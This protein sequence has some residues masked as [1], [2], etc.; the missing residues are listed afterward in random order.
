MV[1]A[2]APAPVDELLRPYSDELDTGSLAQT[3]GD[4]LTG[5]EKGIQGC[6]TL[7][8]TPS[9]MKVG[10]SA[11]DIYFARDL[12]DDTEW[13]VKGSL[14]DQDRFLAMGEAA[15]YDLAHRPGLDD[16]TVPYTKYGNF[17][18][19]NGEDGPFCTS[20]S[21]QEFVK[22]RGALPNPKW[23]EDD[24]FGKDRT[25]FL[26]RN[27]VFDWFIGNFD[28]HHKNFLVGRDGQYHAIDK[29]QAFRFYGKDELSHT[30]DTPKVWTPVYND[31]WTHYIEGACEVDLDAAEKVIT[32]IEAI[33]DQEIEEILRP[34]ALEREKSLQAFNSTDSAFVSADDFIDAVIERKNS[35]RGDFEHFYTEMQQRRAESEKRSDPVSRELIDTGR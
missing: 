23:S 32:A 13:V 10:E 9:H 24:Y 34:Y 31:M 7:L 6:Y 1:S 22:N 27:Q 33:P 26:V 16:I 17:L 15:V 18:V 8:P 35:L 28:T 21:S 30:Y 20:G 25:D 4:Y 3:I 5:T 11:C 14:S 12:K 29:G 2:Y 19:L